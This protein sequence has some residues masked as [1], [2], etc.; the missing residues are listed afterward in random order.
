MSPLALAFLFAVL[1]VLALVGF[2]PSLASS[3]RSRRAAR[4]APEHEAVRYDPGRE[5][6][7][8]RRA[9]GLLRSAVGEADFELYEA[10]GFLRVAG[11]PDVGG[12]SAYGYLVY[13]HRPIVSYD[14]RSGELLSEHCVQFP[15]RS[16]RV[17]G[18]RLPDAD[19]VL[20]K[21]LSLHGAERRLMAGANT[22]V[23]GRQIDPGQVRRDLRR[24][25]EWERARAGAAERDRSSAE[26]DPLEAHPEA[27]SRAAAGATNGAG[28]AR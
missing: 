12:E 7:A 27:A 3:W 23:P 9:K 25:L 19:D 24:L 13:P 5:R 20:A 16:E 4:A 21:W 26:R 15:D 11:P 6:R 10:L 17:F 14:A 18:P 2:G 22:H 8:E 1:A 28:P